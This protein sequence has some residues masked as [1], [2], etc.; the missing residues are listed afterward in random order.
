VNLY[1]FLHLRNGEIVSDAAAHVWTV[2]EWYE[3]TRPLAICQVGF[4]ASEH[5]LDALTN[6]AGSVLAVVEV[7]GESEK[8]S[9]KQCWQKMRIVK[10]YEWRKEDS[11]SLAI[12]AAEMVIG[13]FEARYPA[14]D[15]PRKAIE[16]AKSWLKDPSAADAAARA[17]ADAAADAADAAAY[18]ADAAA[19]AAARA[20]NAARAAC[21]AAAYAGAY[22]A[23]S[24]RA[25]MT[26]KAN[27]WIIERMRTLPEVSHA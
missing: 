4:H 3:E 15:R 18:A 2:G 11:V 20:A 16:A 24:A 9:D 14:D 6:V 27:A 17:A 23:D 21:A 13:L 10:A 26:A 12:F 7:A 25:A 22:A 8:Q 19:D 1:K 5:P